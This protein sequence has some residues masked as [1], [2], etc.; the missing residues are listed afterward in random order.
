MPY[1]SILI[2]HA[3]S[4]AAALL[5]FVAGEL[6][7]IPARW[8]KA[9]PARIALV[10]RRIAGMFAA[11]GV[12]S[13]VVLLVVGGWSP[14]ASWLLASFALIAALMVV[15]RILIRP[16]ETRARSAFREA[17]SVDEVK[18]I[19]G[20]TRA[21]LGRLAMLALFA[22]VAALMVAKPALPILAT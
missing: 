19:A 9:S 2:A 13:G 1:G 14:A 12:V 16:W 17:P 3:G 7:W 10:S 5:L 22:L 21:L 6:L 20:E 15:E 4:M 18:A 8:G 11:I